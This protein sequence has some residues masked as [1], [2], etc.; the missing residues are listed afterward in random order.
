MPEP[1]MAC[2]GQLLGARSKGIPVSEKDG[3]FRGRNRS[4]NLPSAAGHGPPTTLFDVRWASGGHTDP[5]GRGVTLVVG[6][7]P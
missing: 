1:A 4:R 3:G 6:R 5:L 7:G 2:T